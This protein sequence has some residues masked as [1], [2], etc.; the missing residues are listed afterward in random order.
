MLG[1]SHQR[2]IVNVA[3]LVLADHCVS[4]EGADRQPI[5]NSLHSRRRCRPVKGVD[6]WPDSQAP[7]RSTQSLDPIPTESMRSSIR[8]SR[9][10][11]SRRLPIS[12]LKWQPATWKGSRGNRLD[13]SWQK[14]LISGCPSWP[15]LAGGGDA[16]AASTLKAPAAQLQDP[17][18]N[19][20]DQICHND[21]TPANCRDD[22]AALQLER[23]G[24]LSK[25]RE[26]R[27]DRREIASSPARRRGTA[28]QSSR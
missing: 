28:D 12:S 11:R 10:Y 25:A 4:Y 22:H 23:G 19:R 18:G 17:T 6:C 24:G 3:F 20:R 1:E 9:S 27:A 2:S 5:R 26:L 14:K 8:R 13:P 16:L 21:G 15:V 7:G